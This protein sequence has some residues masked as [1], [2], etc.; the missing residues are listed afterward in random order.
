[1]SFVDADVPYIT[2]EMKQVITELK[3]T[4]MKPDSKKTFARFLSFVPQIIS[5]S[6]NLS[7]VQKSFKLTGMYPLDSN[8]ILKNCSSWHSTPTAQ[9][10]AILDA[11]DPLIEI[12]RTN[13]WVKDS[14]IHSAV[15]DLVDFGKPLK[16][17]YTPFNQRRACW[18]N[19]DQVIVEYKRVKQEKA[20]KLF[21]EEQKKAKKEEKRAQKKQEVEA[22]K[23]RKS[24]AQE[25]DR[26]EANAKKVK[27]SYCS[28]HS[29]M[30]AWS[31]VEEDEI[32][33]VYC[34]HKGCQL[35]FCARKPCKIALKTHQKVCP[36]KKSEPAQKQ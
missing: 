24:E 10:H 36:K 9:A 11:I 3:A 27:E 28:N 13:G 29:C 20:V 26:A 1:M 5:K 2:P 35:C 12:A 8:I 17:E 30:R 32:E 23:K 16:T 18:G 19:H 33:W 7:S 34:E 4:S 14:E 31:T 6:I 25:V 22:A 15:G 21:E